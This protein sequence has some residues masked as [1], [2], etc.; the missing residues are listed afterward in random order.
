MPE[1]TKDISVNSEIVINHDYSYTK[2]PDIQ[3][4]QKIDKEK[5]KKANDKNI[6]KEKEKSI[7]LHSTKTEIDDKKDK[8]IITHDRTHE[9]IN[10]LKL[11]T[12]K[13]IKK[14]KTFFKL[15]N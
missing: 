9:A 7:V 2:N 14:N 13:E 12:L 5:I 15:T 8:S 10:E 11:L 3:S 6:N 4:I 1:K